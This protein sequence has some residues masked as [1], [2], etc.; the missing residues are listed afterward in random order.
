MTQL[1]PQGKGKSK[2]ITNNA[3]SARAVLGKTA[4]RLALRPLGRPASAAE[5]K[6]VAPAPFIGGAS[7]GEPF[8]VSDK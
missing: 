5:V 3:S 4:E 1:S 6:K 8:F 7:S 2:V